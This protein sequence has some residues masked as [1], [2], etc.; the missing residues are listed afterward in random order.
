[1]LMLN[2]FMHTAVTS[3]GIVFVLAHLFSTLMLEM[4]F[5]HAW[6]DFCY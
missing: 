5:T 4:G 1:M 2:M 3:V 6:A